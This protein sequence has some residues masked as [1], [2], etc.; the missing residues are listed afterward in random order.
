M[1]LGARIKELRKQNGME[2]K[3]LARLLNI[4]PKTI[5][6]WEVNR[7]QPKM[8]FIS[9]MCEIFHCRKSDFLED[10]EVDIHI[11][12]DDFDRILIEN[13]HQAD[14]LDRELVNRILGIERVK[15]IIEK[16]SEQYPPSK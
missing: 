11:D 16:I 5:S 10:K 15:A 9:Q 7:T 8:E 6:S 2:Q 13:Y 3:D 14:E 4:S 1:D 12:M